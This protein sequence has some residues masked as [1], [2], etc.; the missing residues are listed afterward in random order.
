MLG[1]NGAGNRCLFSF[2]QPDVDACAGMV[3]TATV[4]LSVAKRRSC[5]LN[6]FYVKALVGKSGECARKLL[7]GVAGVGQV[8]ISNHVRNNSLPIRRCIWTPS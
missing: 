5:L 7:V 1:G 2:P 4:V 3:G 8:F 6:Y